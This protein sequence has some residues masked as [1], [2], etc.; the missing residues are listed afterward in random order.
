MHC[1]LA[2]YAIHTQHM[3]IGDSRVITSRYWYYIVISQYKTQVTHS[4]LVSHISSIKRLKYVHNCMMP[5]FNEV[6]ITSSLINGEVTI[7]PALA[8]ISLTD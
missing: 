2:H 4:M 1:K 7:I 5:I 3:E 6:V 8:A